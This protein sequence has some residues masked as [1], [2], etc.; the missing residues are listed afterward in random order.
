M[1][2]APELLS[3]T[4]LLSFSEQRGSQSQEPLSWSWVTT[5]SRGRR[6]LKARRPQ[7]WRAGPTLSSLGQTWL[8]FAEPRVIAAAFAGDDA[9][10][11]LQDYAARQGA[12]LVQDAP[13]VMGA[14]AAFDGEFDLM[15]EGTPFARMVMQALSETQPGDTLS[16]AD[17]ARR[18]GSPKAARAVG[19]VMATNP[20]APFVPCHRVL[21][22]QRSG[23]ETRDVGQYAYGSERKRDLLDV[24]AELA[25]LSLKSA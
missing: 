7:P 10:A 21:P 15:L 9:L 12:T 6:R 16:Y 11:Q 8:A 14:L 5:G 23:I 24:E 25:A 13:W 18:S 19:Q 4:G 3:V 22:S 2:Y 1:N 17:L 20:L